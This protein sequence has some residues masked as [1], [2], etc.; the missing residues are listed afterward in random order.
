MAK[1]WYGALFSPLYLLVVLAFLAVHA[2]PPLQLLLVVPLA[3]LPLLVLIASI[4]PAA[5][6]SLGSTVRNDL[7]E[8]NESIPGE[9]GPG[10]TVM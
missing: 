8:G 3:R 9:L 10:A 5:A 4:L 2:A 1:T 6:V 7:R